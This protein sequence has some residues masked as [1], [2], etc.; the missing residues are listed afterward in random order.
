MPHEILKPRN[1]AVFK[2]LMS[3]KRLLVSFLQSALDLPPE[4]YDDVQI[5]DPHL[6]GERPED[7]LGVLDVKVTTAQGNIVDIEVQ[8]NSTPEMRERALFYLSRMVTEQVKRGE[9]YR[10]IKRV[11]CILILAYEEIH[12]SLR[13]HNRYWFHDPDSG[14]LFSKAMEVDTLEL[15]KL[16]ESGDETKLCAWLEFIR[17][18]KEEEF[19][20]LAQR[21]PDIGLAVVRLKDLSQD[22]RLRELAISREKLAWDIASREE[23]ARAE[24]REEGREEGQSEAQRAI[25]RKALAEGL[26]LETVMAITGLS[27]ADLLRLQPEGHPRH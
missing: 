10:R 9:D 26:P 8:L 18:T 15:S 3:D 1:D 20:M 21:D 2:R 16:P 5:I 17:A 22:E 19:D 24:G 6:L 13:Y 4:D 11:I 7:K 25:A 27:E 14:S 23:G 12:D